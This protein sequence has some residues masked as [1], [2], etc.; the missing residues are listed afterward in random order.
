MATQTLKKL[1][2]DE[3]SPNP[4]NPR[5]HFDEE[6][7]AELRTSITKVGILVP[8]TVFENPDKDPKEKY[9]L[10]DGER[11]WRCAKELDLEAIPANVVDQPAD[12][13][14]NLIYMFNIHHFREEWDLYAIA[15]KLEAL[16][17]P[18]L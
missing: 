6:T 12:V 10:L 3:I 15:L 16:F 4:H 9:I 5:L 17:E 11:R 8:I 2:P 1:S 13:A 14:Q 18:F 7:M